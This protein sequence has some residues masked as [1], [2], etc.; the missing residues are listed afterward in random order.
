MS[1]KKSKKKEFLNFSDNTF[2]ALVKK[3]FFSDTDF[4]RRFIL[5]F[6]TYLI[7]FLAVIYADYI[8]GEDIRLLSNTAPLVVS[9]ISVVNTV[10][11]FLL[12]TGTKVQD[13]SP[14]PQLVS[15]FVLAM[16]SVMLVSVLCS[17]IT[18]SR[19]MFATC[20]GLTPYFLPHLS[21]KFSSL[22]ECICIFLAILPFVFKNKKT[23]VCASIVSVLL[24]AVLYFPALSIWLIVFS[25]KCIQD[26][27]AGKLKKNKIFLMPAISTI[28]FVLVCVGL[29]SNVLSL[30]KRL[31][32]YYL[33]YWSFNFL[34][35]TFSVLFLFFVGYL[36]ASFI[37]TMKKNRW[38][39]FDAFF[40]S[41]YSIV[42]IVSAVF[43]VQAFFSRDNLFDAGIGLGCVL[44]CMLLF[45]SNTK[46]PVVGKIV[47][48][49]GWLLV[50]QLVVFG[51]KYGNLLM[52][53]KQYEKLSFEMINEV[54]LSKKIDN[55][56]VKPRKMQVPLVPFK[57]EEYP[58]LNDLVFFDLSHPAYFY[59]YMNFFLDARIAPCS[60]SFYAY[61]REE[62]LKTDYLRFEKI[63]SECV[64]LEVI[65]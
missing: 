61:S 43:V 32:N 22:F 26:I 49:V 65:K 3:G 5:C 51:N 15:L 38:Y 10:L 36:F 7:S 40:M 30:L 39:G 53:Q 25:F 57:A 9:K 23:F 52:A 12:F 28:C 42:L 20:L 64:E 29:R 54:I 31:F 50:W 48:V 21:T 27:Q 37:Q 60:D 58:I 2:N 24:V 35:I 18:Y 8:Y 6:C 56:V 45:I 16:A 46:K 4:R 14:L 11:S 62:L 19:V 47:N 33:S 55:I 1:M 63:N 41:F 13:I 17:K 59:D 44:S 34:G